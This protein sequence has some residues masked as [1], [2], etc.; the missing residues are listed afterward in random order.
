MHEVSDL[1]RMWV[2]AGLAA[3]LGLLAGCQ[4]VH[5]VTIDA[6][7]NQAKPMGSSYRLVVHDPTGGVDKELAATAVA[8]I[9]DALA[10]RGLYEAP[11]GLQPDVVI[12]YQ[13]GIGPGEIK[14]VRAPPAIMNSGGIGIQD[15]DYGDKPIIVFEKFISLS[16]REPVPGET[17]GGRGHAT[18]KGD[19]VWNLRVSIEDEKKD[20]APYLPVLASVSVDYMGANSVEEEHV[21]VKGGDAVENLH[22]REAQA[23]TGK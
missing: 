23:R 15:V 2:C 5:D 3:M 9:K 11:A 10:A 4:T 19:E 1:R 6:I 12:D 21:M 20:L 18:K 8:N 13:F 22:R 17:A 16:A 14:I 7:S